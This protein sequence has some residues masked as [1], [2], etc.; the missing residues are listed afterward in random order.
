P[1]HAGRKAR[2]IFSV[3]FLLTDRPSSPAPDTSHFY[4][5]VLTPGIVHRL[6]LPHSKGTHLFQ[7]ASGLSAQSK[8][9]LDC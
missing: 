3:A 4:V 9:V 6:I 7:R 2:L 1:F 5:R 8:Q